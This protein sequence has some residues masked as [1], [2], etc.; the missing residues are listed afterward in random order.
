M[1]VVKGCEWEAARVKEATLLLIDH[2]CGVSSNTPT[3]PA[4]PVSGSNSTNVNVGY[5]HHPST[6]VAFPVT[7]NLEISPVHHTVVVGKNNFNLRVIMQRTNTTILF[8]DAADPN[9]PPIR[10]GS[11]SITGAIHNV[12][13][14][15]QQLIGSLPL[16]MMFD[17][18]EDLEVIDSE[19]HK[20]GEELNVA[21]SIKPK[22]RQGCKSVLI[23]AQERNASSIYAARH[24]LLKM[25]EDEELLVVAD[26]PESY[27]VQPL[28][29]QVV[30]SMGKN[31]A[32]T[33][34]YPWI[35]LIFTFFHFL[36]KRNERPEKDTSLSFLNDVSWT[37]ILADQ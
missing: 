31:S 11:V 22:H 32:T 9:I 29:Q 16:V 10:K 7:M 3:S 2:L 21:I 8:P 15:R 33:L 4:P 28:P 1:A 35:P 23:K 36:N 13:S 14:A 19:V 34:D 12:Y 27:K 17:V 6:S 24:R 5:A 20:I 18:P 26:V 37:S 25:D 30:D